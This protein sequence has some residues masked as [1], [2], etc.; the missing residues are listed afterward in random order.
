[1]TSNEQVTTAMSS[2]NSILSRLAL[3]AYGVSRTATRS[4]RCLLRGRGDRVA[5]LE[6]TKEEGTIHTPLEP[7]D[8]VAECEHGVVILTRF[9][10]TITRRLRW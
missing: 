7:S 8:A 2:S 9:L 5:V 10:S 6:T 1:M 4:P 3:D